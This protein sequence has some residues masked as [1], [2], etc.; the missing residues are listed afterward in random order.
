MTLTRRQLTARAAAMGA[1]L[2][3]GAACA[4]SSAP[5]RRER[6]DLYPQGVA[7]GD[8]DHES[9]IL[10][11]RRPPGPEGEARR[12]VVEV[13]SDPDFRRVAAI[14]ETEVSATADWT[15]RF[16]AAGL[17]PGRE[18]WY[19]FTDEFGFASRV[20]RTLTAPAPNEDRAVHFAFVSCQLVAEGACNA[21]RRMIFEDEAKASAE[22]LD[23]VL[24]LGDFIYEV[25]WYPDEHPGGH[26]RGRRLRDLFKYPDGERI[27]DFHLPVTLADY[28]TVYRAYLEDPDLQDARAR[29]PFVCVWDNHE[30]SWAGWQS[31]Q[32]FG[33]E[34]RPAQTK[35]VAAN[36]AWWEYLPARVIKAGNPALDRFDAPDVVDAL[37]ETFAD[38]GLGLEANNLAAVNSLKIYRTLQW[39]RNVELFLTDNH[40]YRAEPVDDGGAFTPEGF[41]WANSQTASEILDCGR[42]Y[43]DG[44][45]PDT[46][47]FA[48]RDVPNP[49]KQ[50]PPQSYLGAEQKA[51]LLDRLKSS[52][53]RWKIWGHSFGTLEWRS[54]YQNLPP[55]LGPQWPDEGYALFNGGYYIEK[56]EIFDFIRDE[57]ITGFAI[58]AGDRHSFWAGLVSKSLP[59]QEFAPVGV[60]FITGSI[61]SPGIFEVGEHV[62]PRDYVLRPLYLHD[63]PDSAIAPAM[64]MAALHGV[65]AALTLQETGDLTRALGQSN[66]EVSPHLS[67]LDLGGHGYAT[68]TATSEGLETE[69]VAIPRPLERS[70]RPDGGPLAYRVAHRARLWRAGETPQLEQEILEGEPPLATRTSRA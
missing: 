8:P 61:S 9:V 46:I 65:R 51:W 20:G 28:R 44:N 2:A 49:R 56:G 68:V 29:W 11:T 23:F 60:E 55:G 36:Q 57:R 4:H 3:F 50:A 47:R 26:R 24:H 35:K 25:I 40:S 70:E 41:R 31:Q 43:R 18:Y 32:V 58:V 37:I 59:P 69:F 39:G 19:R 12:L 14:G 38:D 66:P 17:Q 30:F 22:R 1:A 45:P 10:W 34:T 63:R 42:A 6:R 67:F 16:L 52:R 64:N 62:I 7:S 33:G 13:A 15:C 54:D 48:G 27:S 5:V 21:Y 53:A